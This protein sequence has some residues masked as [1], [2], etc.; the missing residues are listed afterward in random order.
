M[1]WKLDSATNCFVSQSLIS[2][3]IVECAIGGDDCHHNATCTNTAGSFIC[4]CNPGYTGNGRDCQG[5][6][7]ETS[8]IIYFFLTI[9]SYLSK[10]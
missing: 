4:T 3:D 9:E 1:N 6:Y 8:I 10:L 5:K 7:C 2:L